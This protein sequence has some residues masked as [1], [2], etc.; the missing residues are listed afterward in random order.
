MRAMLD[1]ANRALAA[2]A[3]PDTDEAQLEEELEQCRLEGL[4][5]QDDELAEARAKVE[6]LQKQLSKVKAAVKAHL[7][8]KA[9]Q[10]AKERQLR[11]S[12]F[13]R[14]HRDLGKTTLK[15]Q[16]TT[17]AM[18]AVEEEN[19]RLKAQLEACNAE[20]ARTTQTAEQSRAA[21]QAAVRAKLKADA[22]IPE[23][24]T[25]EPAAAASISN[26]HHSRPRADASAPLRRLVRSG[27]DQVY[28]LLAL[29]RSAG[30]TGASVEPDKLNAIAMPLIDWYIRVHE[31]VDP[32]PSSPGDDKAASAGRPTGTPA[33][34]AVLTKVAREAAAGELP[35]YITPARPA[36]SSQPAS[37]VVALSKSDMA[38]EAVVASL[39]DAAGE[40][41][42]MEA[43]MGSMA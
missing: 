43:L 37:K 41:D 31:L 29:S 1:E 2:T 35:S 21:A 36:A 3:L 10:E 32:A 28:K 39:D 4:Q 13:E 11:A 22:K 30:P 24:P 38:Y 27:K 23:K 9:V 34:A 7:T 16:T 26:S 5:Q 33:P 17:N 42:D 40:E 19:V 15:L 25:P 14:L 20:L 8:K 6:Q 18:V 12:R